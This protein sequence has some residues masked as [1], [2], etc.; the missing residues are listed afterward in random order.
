MSKSKQLISVLVKMRTSA[1]DAVAVE[2]LEMFPVY[3]TGKAYAAGYR[4]QYAG[5]L[6]KVLQEHTSAE[7]WRPD[8]TPA[9]YEVINITHAGTLDD[10]IPYDG[11]MEL[12]E[13]KYYSQYDIIYH[14]TRGTGQ[15]VY[16]DLADLINIYVEVV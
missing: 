12:E 9:L 11:N 3:Q 15:A 8:A 6:Y 14:C 1:P 2:G 7:E 4:F 13:G 5:K 16:N 10:P